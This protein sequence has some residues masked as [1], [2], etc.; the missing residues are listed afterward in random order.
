MATDGKYSVLDPDKYEIYVTTSESVCLADIDGTTIKIV[1]G[2]KAVEI[3]V[4]SGADVDDPNEDD[5]LD[6]AEND[7]LYIAKVADAAGNKTAKNRNEVD[8]LK[9]GYS[10][11]FEEHHHHY[12]GWQAL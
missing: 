5:Y 10:A 8:I 4:P 12:T 3:K 7:T 1:D 11:D 9:G 2:G 6:I